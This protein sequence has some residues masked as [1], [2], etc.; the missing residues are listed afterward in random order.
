MRFLEF[1][2]RDQ[3]IRIYIQEVYSQTSQLFYISDLGF[4]GP[5]DRSSNSVYGNLLYIAPEIIAGKEITF[6]SD[7]YSIGILR[8]SKKKF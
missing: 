2:R 8:P 6:A 1:I 7:I 3:F 4:C 5:A